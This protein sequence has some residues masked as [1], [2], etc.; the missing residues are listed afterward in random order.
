MID[1][2]TPKFLDKSS[3][4][5]LVRKTSLIDALNIYVDVETGGEGTGGVIK[6]IK[7]TEGI[8]TNQYDIPFSEVSYKAIGSVTDESTGIVYFFV[9]S[10]SAEEHGVWA[11]DHRGVLPQYNSDNDTFLAGE[12]KAL[13]RIISAKEFDFPVNGFVKGDIVYSNTREF[14]NYSA[15][16]DLPYPQK[17]AI[18]YFTD[19]KNEPRK[20]NIYR[21]FLSGYPA[22][23]TQARK[24]FISACPRVPL[25]RPTFKFVADP[26]RD[27]NNFATAPGFQFA[28][29][30]IYKDGL[31]SAISPYSAAA[32]PPS[33]VDRGAI[34]SD[35]TLA[36]NKC[37]ITVPPQNEEVQ[38]IK[39]LARYGNGVNFIEIDE[40]E[41]NA[42]T[43][44]VFDFYNDRIAGGVSPQTTDKTFDNVPQR[45]LAQSV[46]S[47]RLMYGNY[48]EGYDNVDCSGVNLEPVY[49]DRPPEILDYYL[50]ITPSVEICGGGSQDSSSGNQKTPNKTMG[51]TYTTEQFSNFIPAN[52]KVIVSFSMSPDKNFHFYNVGD[53]THKSY[54]QTKQVGAYSLNLSGYNEDEVSED[55]PAFFQENNGYGEP[56]YLNDAAA[57][58]YFLHEQQENYFGFTKGLALNDRVKWKQ[59]SATANLSLTGGSGEREIAFGT[60]GANPLIVRGGKLTFKLEFTVLAPVTSGGAELIGDMVGWLLE[61][62]GQDYVDAQVGEGAVTFDE[63]NVKRTHI[64]EFNLGLE[65]YAPIPVDSD[66][67]SLIC[68]GAIVPT[69]ANSSSLGDAL[70]DKAPSFAFIVNKARVGF[71]LQKSTERLPSMHRAFSIGVGYVNVDSAEDVWTCVRDLDPSSPWWAISPSKMTGDFAAN[72]TQEWE[73]NLQVPNR[74][75]RAMASASPEPHLGFTRNFTTKLPMRVYSSEGSMYEASPKPIME[76]CFGVIKIVADESG[77]L[78]LLPHYHDI[79]QMVGTDLGPRMLVSLQDGEGGPG[80]AG[81]GEGS[82]YDVLECHRLGSIAGQAFIGVDESHIEKVRNRHYV[83]YSKSLD[84]GLGTEGGVE[85]QFALEYV[86]NNSVADALGLEEIDQPGFPSGI[87][88]QSS[89]FMG[90]YYTG[91]I[92]L[93]NIQLEQ[94][95]G[96]VNITPLPFAGTNNSICGFTT[97]LPLV[98]FSSWDRFGDEGNESSQDPIITA[99]PILYD[100]IGSNAFY[101]DGE[102]QVSY[103]NPI[104][105]PGTPPSGGELVS[106][107]LVQNPFGTGYNSVDFERTHSHAE[108]NSAVTDYQ[109]QGQGSSSFKTS[110]THELG[111]VY[112]D[113]R[114]RHGRVNPIG[115]VYVPGYGERNSQPKGRT[116]I[117]ASNITHTP[118]SWAKKYKFAYSKNTSVDKFIQYSSGGAFIARSDYEGGNPTSIYVSLNYLQGH[119]ISYSDSFGARG[120]DN[121]PVMY[122]FTPGD[123]LRVISYMLSQ[124]GADIS[125]VYPV[126]AEFEVTG[127]VNLTNSDDHPFPVIAD[128]DSEIPEDRKGLFLVLKNNNDAGG[129]RYQS[130]DQGED[131]WGSNCIFEIYSPVK[132]VDRE[133]RLYYEI[134]DA[135]DVVYAYPPQGH[136]NEGVLGYYHDF[137]SVILEDGDV[138]FRRHA[139][140]LREFDGANGFIDMINVVDDEGIP[141]TAEPN[142]K[143]YYLESEAATDLFKARAISIGRPN[144]VDLD[145]KKTFREASIIHSDKDIVESRKVGYSSFNRT[146]PSDLEID[147][148]PGPINYLANHQDSIFFVQK[149]KCG[150]IPVDRTLIS[151]TA[152]TSSLIASSKFLGTPRY[153][154]GEAGCDDNP[155]SV[156]SVDN[157]AYFANKSSGRVFKVSGANGVNVISDKGVSEYIR[158]QFNAATSGGSNGVRVVGGYDPLKK[159]YLLTVIGNEFSGLSG[160]IGGEAVIENWSPQ[161]QTITGDGVISFVY[162]S[163]DAIEEEDVLVSKRISVDWNYASSLSHNDHAYWNLVYTGDSEGGNLNGEFSSWKPSK[164]G[165]SVPISVDA[166]IVVKFIGAGQFDQASPPSL[167]IQT[168]FGD[169]TENFSMGTCSRNWD[170]TVLDGQ[171]LSAARAALEEAGLLG[172]GA[173][174]WHLDPEATNDPDIVL[175][176]SF[177]EG[178]GYPHE[179]RVTLNNPSQYDENEIVEKRIGVRFGCMPDA[180]VSYDGSYEPTSDDYYN[181]IN[182][183]IINNM[184]A[185]GGLFSGALRI[186]SDTQFSKGGLDDRVNEALVQ[187]EGSIY[188]A[189]SVPQVDYENFV[190]DADIPLF[191]VINGG[192]PIPYNVCHPQYG[193]VNYTDGYLTFQSFTS[194]LNSSNGMAL[195]LS[196]STELSFEEAETFLDSFDSVTLWGEVFTAFEPYSSGQSYTCPNISYPDEPAAV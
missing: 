82:A 100:T 11:Y 151:D 47:N 120:R 160:G 168:G 37:E 119:P 165:F 157:A 145:A 69:A 20:V 10:E 42:G 173:T 45:A 67:G 9:W 27:V 188:I 81:A 143:S 125:R 49:L 60:S 182:P 33:I 24:D 148:K 5:K 161:D 106:G 170:L 163:E 89:A 50:E 21:A 175:G 65:D 79:D 185:T 150:H 25:D 92:V 99:D 48:V 19:N 114:G 8:Q 64:H 146:I 53:L 66:L 7:G 54:H 128:G 13:R 44:F 123:R 90:P 94:N 176:G 15:L 78:N 103:A 97:T 107:T 104:V 86:V 31:E 141:V 147:T 35:Q 55:S 39:I 23:D 98:L 187:M 28:Y 76:S 121:T 70:K 101:N 189:A 41:N 171:D 59:T 52:T 124:N 164:E 132:E 105:A 2:L 26:D 174:L 109:V 135:Y 118:P 158:N 167:Y 14:D 108:L 91:R 137:E 186:S 117:K 113:E 133:D 183:F 72:P 40:V 191:N 193:L 4:Y 77:N 88:R 138:Y 153:Y 29:Q 30:N 83:R 155:E 6:P 172:P 131:N 93:N 71:Y 140:N 32:F 3:D 75:F 142:F 116:L 1:K 34:A 179:L 112:Y 61:G 58:G 180:S 85:N 156:V 184:D 192:N 80:G 196:E 162:Q 18:L 38:S 129:F 154:V 122:S 115:S 62:R 111:I 152:G 178:G 51:F 149:N 195:W 166:E 127:V 56:G 16:K 177:A 126:G 169:V 36:H 68:G 43:A 159:E 130:V 96:N 12:K 46:V 194:F 87:H 73:N 22:V 181:I 102:I 84:E 134:G 63:E 57:G 74:I 144:I 17:D 136:P 190:F 139:V 110:A 95:I